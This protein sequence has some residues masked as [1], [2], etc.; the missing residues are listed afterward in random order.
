MGYNAGRLGRF[1]SKIVGACF[2][3]EWLECGLCYFKTV[4]VF[5]AETES[6]FVAY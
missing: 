1:E 2:V 3:H 6:L 5:K 4:P